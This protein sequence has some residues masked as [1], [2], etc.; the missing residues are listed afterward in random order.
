MGKYFGT[1]GFRGEANV[2]L[3]Y[4]HAIKIGRSLGWYYGA[5]IGKKANSD[6]PISKSEKIVYSVIL[7]G[8]SA[9]HGGGG[10]QPAPGPEG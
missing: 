9:P 4:D 7:E 1:D 5:R 3:N 10:R 2:V 8:V 6:F